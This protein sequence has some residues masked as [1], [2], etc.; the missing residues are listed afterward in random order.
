MGRTLSR[1]MMLAAAA[2]AFTTPAVVAEGEFSAN[3]ALTTDYVWRGFSQNSENPSVQGGFDYS[4]GLFYAG[5]WAAIVDF[6]G[7]NMELD[8]YGGLA[9]ETAGGIAW[10]LGVIGYVYPDTED[11]DFV[12][13]YGGL[14]YSFDIVDVGAYVYYDPD[15]ETVYT[16]ASAGYSFS[17]TFGLDATAGKYLDGFDEYFNASIG[18]TVATEFVDVDLRFWTS[19]V[20]EDELADERVVVT[21]SRSF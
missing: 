16:E 2:G 4:N 20:D 10:D 18:A 19:D 9:G 7:G 5:T 6:G 15:N 21:V 3:V 12:E 11:L 14:G 17:D 13:V 1:M 8:L